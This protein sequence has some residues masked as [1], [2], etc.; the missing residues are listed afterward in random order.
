MIISALQEP[1]SILKKYHGLGIQPLIWIYQPWIDPGDEQQA[2]VIRLKRRIEEVVPEGYGGYIGLNW[3]KSFISSLHNYSLNGRAWKMAVKEGNK[4]LD[5]VRASRPDSKAGLYNP[6]RRCPWWASS[7]S[8]V[9]T[10]HEDS[11]QTLQHLK[12]DFV[13]VQCYQT[14]LDRDWE[15]ESAAAALCLAGEYHGIVL[16]MDRLH[17]APVPGAGASVKLRSQDDYRV[18]ASAM[19]GCGATI[20]PWTPDVFARRPNH[21]RNCDR[22]YGVISEV[23]T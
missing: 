20:S 19:V 21:A 17:T 4:A 2:D 1:D 16:G 12:H 9:L 7:E 18:W 8:K 6:M 13:A 22:Y 15:L 14:M 5:V 23:V 11:R 10:W 3:E